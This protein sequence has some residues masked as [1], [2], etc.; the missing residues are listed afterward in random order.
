MEKQYELAPIQQVPDQPNKIEPII[1]IGAS[2][3]E[4][5]LFNPEMEIEQAVLPA[6]FDFSQYSHYLK[7][8][9]DFSKINSDQATRESMSLLHFE[10]FFSQQSQVEAGRTVYLDIDTNTINATDIVSGTVTEIEL[11]FFELWEQK[12]MPGLLIHTHPHS[13]MPSA[14]DYAPLLK[15]YLD[16]HTRIIRGIIVLCPETQILALATDQTPLLPVTKVD[17]MVLANQKLITNFFD[18]GSILLS[19]AVKKDIQKP[20]TDLSRY[21]KATTHLLEALGG[22]TITQEEFDFKISELEI[23]HDQALQS[24]D[25]Q[26]RER[27]LRRI[28]PILNRFGNAMLMSF[29]RDAHFKLYSAVDMANF[30]EFSA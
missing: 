29:A 17:E 13:Q 19:K 3:L 24:K 30:K 5:Y 16:N 18:K 9:Y 8:L 11:P 22:G 23:K 4:E 27:T 12:K 15:D 14:I 7:A 2:D 10:N 21:L 25:N 20:L 6:S 28:T 26:I 1:T